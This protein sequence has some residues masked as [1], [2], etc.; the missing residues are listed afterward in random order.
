MAYS[1]MMSLSG[2]GTSAKTS[3]LFALR[4]AS[5]GCNCQGNEAFGT[6]YTANSIEAAFAES[7]VHECG[8]F[9]GGSDAVPVAELTERSV[10]RFACERRKTLALADLTG[11]ALKAL[12]LSNDISA[13][14]DYTTAPRSE[15]E[16][17]QPGVRR[18]FAGEN[19]SAPLGHQLTVTETA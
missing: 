3:A 11:V 18:P 6:C 15:R 9:V 12:G 19:R 13:S 7:V 14:G 5:K 4:S 8:R 2:P 17:R 1:T 16:G 10:V